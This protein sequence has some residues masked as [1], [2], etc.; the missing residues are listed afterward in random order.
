[1]SQ[2]IGQEE[3]ELVGGWGSRGPCLS[4]EPRMRLCSG[5][6]QTYRRR[7]EFTDILASLNPERPLRASWEYLYGSGILGM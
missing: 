6:E 1:M 3:S 5:M 2:L 4:S 7:A